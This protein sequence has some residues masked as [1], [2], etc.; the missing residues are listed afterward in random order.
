MKNQIKELEADKKDL[1]VKHNVNF[2]FHKIREANNRIEELKKRLDDFNAQF[3]KDMDEFASK[4]EKHVVDDLEYKK[5]LFDNG[6]DDFGGEKLKGFNTTGRK[7]DIINQ[8]VNV[9]VINN[10][11]MGG[12]SNSGGGA[13]RKNY[14]KQV[15]TN[16]HMITAFQN[17]QTD[18]QLNSNNGLMSASP[19][20]VHIKQKSINF[21]EAIN[22]T[23]EVYENKIQSGQGFHDVEIYDS[24]IPK[25]IEEVKPD[26][27][28]FFLIAVEKVSISFLLFFHYFLN[29]I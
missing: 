5:V 12:L 3:E 13:S 4:E 28:P 24:R 26:I 22:E 29:H 25:V 9:N 16:I 18:D 19:S 8:S 21:E 11:H 7:R 6:V 10:F 14:N 1:Q 17:M 15:S 2:Y 27:D 20:T 23:K